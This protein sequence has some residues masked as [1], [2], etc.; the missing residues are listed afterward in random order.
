MNVVGAAAQKEEDPDHPWSPGTLQYYGRA[1]L[2]TS[3]HRY[4][5]YRHSLGSEALEHFQLFL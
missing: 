1:E 4:R 3:D 2:K 5:L